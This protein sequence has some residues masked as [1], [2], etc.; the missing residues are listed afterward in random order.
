MTLISEVPT[1]GGRGDRSGLDGIATSGYDVV[2]TLGG[3]G[4]WGS[5]SDI[6]AAESAVD[7]ETSAAAA[8]LGIGMVFSSLVEI[9]G[10]L[11][12]A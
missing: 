5:V 2:T 3:S 9:F 10:E 1:L 8:G 7:V 11:G 12:G 4:T 6:T